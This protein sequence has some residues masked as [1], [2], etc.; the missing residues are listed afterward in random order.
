MI[1]HR[2]EPVDAIEKPASEWQLKVLNDNLATARSLLAD[3]TGMT[4]GREDLALEAAFWAQLPGNFA[5]RPRKA[6]ITSR[7]FAAMAGFHNFPCGRATGNHW[8]EALTMF[9]TAA[10]TPYYFSYHASDPQD[11]EG[12]TKKDIGHALIIGPTGS[13]KTALIAFT[14]CELQ[15]FGVTS[16]LFTKDRD[17]EIC[18]RALGGRYYPIKSGNPTGWNPFQLEGTASNIQ[19]LGDLVRR[20]VSRQDAPLTVTDENELMEAIRSVMSFDP[21]HRRL[22]RVLDYLDATKPEGIY[23]RLKQ[24]CHA[25]REH[26]QDGP[27]AWIFDNPQDSLIESF[28]SVLTTGF[29]VTEFLDKPL[30]RTPINMYLFHLTDQLIDG[31]RFALFIAEFWKALDD[32]Y[33]GAFAKDQLKT[34]R[35]KNGFVVLDS[36]SPSDAIRHPHSRTLIEQTPT[37]ICFPN[38]DATFEDYAT[39]VGLNLTEREYRLIKQDIPTGSRMFL[40]KQGHNSVIAKLDLKGFDAELSV[41]SARKQSIERMER[42]IERYGDDPRD[43][44]P[45]FLAG[46][47]R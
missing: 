13:G 26:D 27:Y 19:F 36:Q 43:W 29:D 10:G 21:P 45:P 4:I 20:L 5:F 30:L 23:V 11:P 22:G 12:G 34:I 9:V 38:P 7:N 17:T 3:Q 31:R 33:F 41:L 6:P 39:D 15:A 32:E 35:K 24:W 47:R 18:I 42:V 14:L 16:V 46:D 44:L 8:G 25:R 1:H 28:G 40:V 37:K 2:P